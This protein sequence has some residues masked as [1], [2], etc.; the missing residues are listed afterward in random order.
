M[1]RP[2]PESSLPALLSNQPA[3]QHVLGHPRLL[4]SDNALAATLLSRI[5]D[6]RTGSTEF[7]ALASELARLALWEA[8]RTLPTRP[9]RVLGFGGQDIGTNTLTEHITGVI[10][11]RAGLAFASPF[12]AL[13]GESPLHQVGLRRDELTLQPIVY[14]NNLPESFPSPAR[15]L[16]LDPMLATGGSA[17]AALGLVRQRHTGP[18][19]VLSLIAAPLGV[20][21]VLT[22]DSQC[23]VYT[24]ALDDG[25][26]EHGF[27]VPGL[28]DAGDR[29]FGTT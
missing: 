23:R 12:R 14:A 26:N 16:L 18:L 7:T 27:I 20:Q 1:S 28:G 9:A 8:C 15:V 21:Q 3:R 22:A 19:D 4:I 29:L 13:F 17:L 2:S 24:V 6:A 11:L 5:R 10:V 25:L